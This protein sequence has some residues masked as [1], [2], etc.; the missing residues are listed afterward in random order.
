M[1]SRSVLSI[2]VILA[3]LACGGAVTLTPTP[4]IP[5][6]TPT[7]SAVEK[8]TRTLSPVEGPGLPTP[9]KAETATMS[10]VI[11][12]DTIALSD[13]RR[14]RYIGMNT[15][16]RDQPYYKE[17]SEA[18]RQWVER[19]N[20]QLEFDVEPFDQYGRV[21]AYVWAEGKLVNL[22]ILKAG[23]A[24][25]FTVPP[26][27]KYEARFRAVEREARAAGRG[28]WTES[29]VGLKITHLQ[30]DAPGSDAE[31]PNGEWV[32]IADQGSQ[33]VQM[34]GY[35][36]KD[37]ANHIYTFGDFTVASGAAFRLYSGQGQNS[38]TALYWGLVGDSVWNNNTDTAFLRD[39]QGA[40]VDVFTY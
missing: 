10:Q 26:N 5:P 31:N 24:N 4:V 2:L 28:L 32:E 19:K 21:L 8:P 3:V 27:V 30:A 18:N 36:L 40:L 37:Q 16:E 25:A 14:V 15:P 11:D 29:T 35:T 34:R 6:P 33:P 1:I 13:G 22:E 9:V 38:P 23:Y 20:I 12:G 39:T 7:L 17:A